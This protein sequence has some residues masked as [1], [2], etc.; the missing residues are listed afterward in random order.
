LAEPKL[1]PWKTVARRK[2]L[3]HGRYLSVESHT[4]QL[5][6][7]E[8]IED[9]PWVIVPDAVIVLAE[10]RDGK[11]V[12]FRQTKYAVEG[13]SLAPVGGLIDTGEQP[14]QAAKR[15]LLEETGYSSEEWIDLGSYVLEPNRG[16]SVANLFLARGAERI[17][18]PD[19]D[20]LEDQQLLLMERAELE[21]ALIWG[22]FKVVTWAAVVALALLHIARIDGDP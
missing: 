22:E 17:A 16:V 2:I 18:D 11:Y 14:I 10:T 7:G 8:V 20:D 5:P 12:C 6:D 15:E 1:R 21:D 4:I 13:T 19:S 3:D 9:W